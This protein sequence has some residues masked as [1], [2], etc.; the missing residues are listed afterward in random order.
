MDV[1]DVV[2]NSYQ[3]S[4]N[5]AQKLKFSQQE[6]LLFTPNFSR[7]QGRASPSPFPS[8]LGMDRSHW[9]YKLKR[10]DDGYLAGLGGFLKTAEE[11]RLKKG[12]SYIWCPCK[13]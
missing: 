13:D 3:L 8:A 7:S 1:V 10:S 5:D 12:E 6:S 2:A 11:N 4:R 9:M